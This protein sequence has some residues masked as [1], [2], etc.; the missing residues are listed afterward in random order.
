MDELSLKKKRIRQLLMIID[1]N[2]GVASLTL[3]ETSTKVY[4]LSLGNNR[5]YRYAPDGYYSVTPY[6]ESASLISDILF[7]LMYPTV[8]CA[9]VPY[10][11]FPPRLIALPILNCF[12]TRK[13]TQEY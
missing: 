5:Y 10:F 3:K 9:M 2:V 7:I 11:S 1:N 13:T 12:E 4:L 8:R 6:L